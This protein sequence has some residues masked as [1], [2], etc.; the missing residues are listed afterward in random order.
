VHRSKQG[1]IIVGMSEKGSSAVSFY[2]VIDVS[3]E[4]TTISNR[5]LLHMWDEK[6]SNDLFYINENLMNTRM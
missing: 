6:K 4:D 5:K 3:C 2:G 1:I